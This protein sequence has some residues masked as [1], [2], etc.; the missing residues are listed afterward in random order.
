MKILLDESLPLKLR[1]DF[2][3]EH[4]VSTVRDM[5]WL[6]QKNGALLKLMTDEGFQV[7][8]TVD[9]NLPYQQDTAALPVKIFVLCA[10]NNRRETL[11]ALIPK[12]LARLSGDSNLGNVTEIS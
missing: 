8:V 10:V 5:S 12:I 3:E 7:F 6:G 4:E 11:R 1:Y 9:R 2:G